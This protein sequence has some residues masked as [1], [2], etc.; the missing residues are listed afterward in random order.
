MSGLFQGKNAKAS[1]SHVI[2]WYLYCS[3]YFRLMFEF[4]GMI[5]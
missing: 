2:I 5:Y 1:G 4:Q 3:A